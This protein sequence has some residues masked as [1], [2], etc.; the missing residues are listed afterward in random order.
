MILCDA[1][2]CDYLG[3]FGGSPEIV[4][5]AHAMYTI[6]RMHMQHKDASPLQIVSAMKAVPRL[7]EILNLTDQTIEEL[8]HLF[9]VLSGMDPCERYLDALLRDPAQAGTFYYDQGIS[10]AAL[11]THIIRYLIGQKEDQR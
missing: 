5:C 2:F 7:L 8:F 11:A 3:N 6:Q 10:A 9:S 4:R 1:A